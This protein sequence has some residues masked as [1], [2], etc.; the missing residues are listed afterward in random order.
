MAVGGQRVSTNLEVQ[1]PKGTRNVRAMWEEIK[2]DGPAP[3]EW[4]RINNQREAEA[5]MTDW[6]KAHFSQASETPLAKG[7]WKKE[8]D[9]LRDGDTITKLLAGEYSEFEGQHEEVAQWLR[10]CKKKEGVKEEV[11]LSVK[12]EEF[13]HF[14]GTV[15]ESKGSS[16]SGRHYGHYK[17]LAEDESLLRILFDIVDIALQS[18]TVLERWRKVHQMLLLKDPPECKIHRFRNITLIEGDLFFL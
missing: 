8:L 15:I 6:C 17:V 1:V 11:S 10:E 5:M 16:P 13:K 7:K 2:G 18:G 4:D 9:L 12:W 14:A 3:E